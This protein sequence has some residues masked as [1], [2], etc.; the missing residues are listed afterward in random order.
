MQSQLN[1]LIQWCST[2]DPWVRSGL[3]CHVVWP[4]AYYRARNLAAG[5]QWQN[6]MPLSCY[7]SSEPMRS[8]VVHMMCPCMLDCTCVQWGQHE[9]GSHP[10]PNPVLD[11][12]H[13]PIPHHSSNL[14]GQKLSTTDLISL[15]LCTTMII[16][17]IIQMHSPVL[18][19][20][21]YGCP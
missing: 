16:L 5:E 1:H 18:E 11:L 7:Q 3:Q 19:K 8:Q 13:R 12:M 15:F 4:L 10:W 6:Q 9:T 21:P 2:S 17:F 20:H 14:Q